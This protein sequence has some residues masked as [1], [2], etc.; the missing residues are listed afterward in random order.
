MFEK[1]IRELFELA[2]RVLN[3]TDYFVSFNIAAHTHCCYIDIMN[4]KWEPKK[5]VDISYTIYIDSEFLKE[6]SLKQYKLA[7]AHLLRLL[8]KG[9]CPL[10][11]ESDGIEA[12][13]NNG[14][15]SDSE[16]ASDGI[17]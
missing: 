16:R 12:P 6:E 10:N 9:R 8:E 14:A 4:S 11:V 7:K 5:K 3:E 15:G 1:E 2:W 13:A 17:E